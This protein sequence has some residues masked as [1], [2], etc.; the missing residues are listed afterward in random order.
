MNIRKNIVLHSEYKND[1]TEKN[2]KNFGYK[3]GMDCKKYDQD[4]DERIDELL[5]EMNSEK[6]VEL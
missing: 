2:L 4:S 5:N 3:N 1:I 6:N